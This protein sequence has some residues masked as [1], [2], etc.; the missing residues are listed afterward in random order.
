MLKKRMHVR[1][2]NKAAVIG[3]AQPGLVTLQVR[4]R[5]IWRTIAR[6][7]T[8]AT[9]R[10]VLRDRVRRPMSVFARVSVNG[11]AQRIGR[12][13]GYRRAYASWYGPGLYGNHLGCGGTLTPRKLGVA[14]KTL[15]CGTKLTLRHGGRSVT[16]RVIDRGPYVAGREF[17][18]TERTA[19]RLH[20]RGHG[21]ILTTR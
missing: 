5:G 11:V 20:F 2:G 17:D 21:T 1:V 16:V 3:S 19:R 8:T 7:R 15:P 18:L 9:G 12:L 10:Y 4:R 6:D 14:H 13:N